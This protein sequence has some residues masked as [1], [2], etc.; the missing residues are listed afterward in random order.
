VGF[1][2]DKWNSAEDGSRMK[3]SEDGETL[4]TER[5]SS[6]E[7][8]HDHDITKVDKPSGS[9]KEISVGANADRSRDK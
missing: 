9:V 8:P 6:E 1:E 3:V 2:K 4:K 7:R 5:I